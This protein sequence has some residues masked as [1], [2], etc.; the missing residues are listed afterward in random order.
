MLHRP[1]LRLVL[2]LVALSLLS[3]SASSAKDPKKVAIL[4]FTMNADRDLGFLQE[5]IAD[6]LGSR[7]AW[8]G[9]LEVVEKGIVRSEVA[10]HKGPLNRETALEIGKRLE[11]DYVILGSL[12]VFGDS[13]SVDARILD[14]AKSD[15]LVTAFN[16]AK[17]MDAVIP[18]I[19]QFAQD[20]NEKVMG[21]PMGPSVQAAA[22]EEPSG[23]GGLIGGGRD[24]EGKGVSHT[25]S[26]KAEIVSLDAGDV[27]GDGKTELVLASPD[28][29][30][31]HKW[32]E[33]GFKQLK[34]YKD[35]RSAHH[36]Y[37][38]VADLN[39]NGKAEIYVSNTGEADVSSFVLEWDGKDLIKIAEKV[40]WFLKV[41]DMPGRGK[42]LVGQRREAGGSFLGD[43]V[44]LN[45]EGNR[46]EKGE[47]IPLHR[48][49]NIFNFAFADFTG[50]GG[51]ET[52][53][54]DFADYLRLYSTGSEQ[55]WK[56]DEPIGG[57]YTFI[58]S[59]NQETYKDHVFISSPIY[60]T[61][62]DE[63]GQKEVMVCKN[64]SKIGRF[65]AKFRDYS[66]GTL[67]FMT[68]DQVGLSTKWQTKKIGGAMVGYRI[69]DFD[70]DN[71]PELVIASVMTEERIY[72][73]PRSR[74]IVYDLK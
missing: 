50:T 49:G 37:V 19:T 53:L 59:D 69:A 63:D 68:R 41:I 21:R 65:L 9:E 48:F 51:I 15:E 17:G 30:Y 67:Q 22:P 14:V 16:Q 47:P 39:G 2:G 44:F 26:V 72:N 45:R 4:P 55:V 18:T 61:D 54:L 28:T 5:G 7:L 56:S 33:K 66:S 36:V 74:I 60:I 42:A 52:V 34:I 20:I 12:T 32:A 73:D 35:K 57:T 40:P 58:K 23:P 11:V 38:S 46:F 10:G 71:L 8:K 1:A 64:T 31:I 62:V 25:Q 6:M 29:V 70:H 27:D 24:F 3:V 13:V 43:V